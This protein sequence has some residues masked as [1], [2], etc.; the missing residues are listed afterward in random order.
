MMLFLLRYRVLVGL[1][2]LLALPARAQRF[3]AIGDYGFAGG[4]VRDVAQLVHSWNP[5]FVITLGDNNYDYGEASTIDANIGQYYHDFIAPYRGQYGP[6]APDNRFFPSLGNHDMATGGGRPYLDY[7][8]LPGNERYYDFVRGQVHFFVLNSDPSEPDGT[9][10]TS[11]QAQWLRAQLAASTAPWKLV[12]FHHPPYSSG[13]HG[14]TLTLRW[15]FREWGASLVLAGHDHHYERLVVDNLL[16]CVN[17]LGGR[18]QYGLTKAALPGSLVRYNAD[19]GAQLLEASADSLRLQFF[20]RA[21]QL[22]DRFTLR[23]GLS[24]APALEDVHPTPVLDVA[25]INFSIPAADV[26]QLRVLDAAGREIKKLLDGPVPAGHHEITWSRAGL[27]PG[28]YFLQLR[29]GPYA[30]VLRTVLL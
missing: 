24:V 19:Y 10:A 30:P 22:I 15:P 5:E 27:A 7:F 16:Y 6:G 23:K 4:P 28:A 17:G 3:A 2:A 29:T 25:R 11:R 21:G 26:V 1:V 12:Y 20:T 14:S 13:E 8:D 18:S 9:S